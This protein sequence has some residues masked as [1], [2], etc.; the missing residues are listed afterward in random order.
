MQEQ[1]FQVLRSWRIR[2]VVAVVLG[3]VAMLAAMAAAL[4]GL[5][6]LWWLFAALM[7]SLVGYNLLGLTRQPWVVKIGPS[8]VEVC[9][10]TGRVMH[11]GWGEI[12]A[13]TITPGGRIGALLVRAGKAHGGARR[14]AVRVLPI[15]T[16]LIGAP[17]TE[18][19]L[20]A[21]KDRLPKLEYRVPSLGGGA[22][23][24]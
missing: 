5:G 9:L 23:P 18:A 2:R 4:Q 22:K 17:A 24:S 13:H 8:G 15:S 21:L 3:L 19:L 16:R 14:G 10:A 7:L 6:W 12:E 1:V 20:A 11:A